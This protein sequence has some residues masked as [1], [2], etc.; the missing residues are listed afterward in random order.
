MCILCVFCLWTREESENVLTL[1]GL[2]PTG[3]L[4][5]GVLSGG[6]QT[7]QTGKCVLYSVTLFFFIFLSLLDNSHLAQPTPLRKCPLTLSPYHKACVFFFY[8]EL[9]AVSKPFIM[10]SWQEVVLLYMI[11]CTSSTSI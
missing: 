11:N 10:S 4:P 2:T 8:F 6:K 5:V 3:T 7:L 9:F 1:K